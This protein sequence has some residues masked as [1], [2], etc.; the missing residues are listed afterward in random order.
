MRPLAR[1]NI[2]L[3]YFP[4]TDLTSTRRRPAMVLWAD[5]GQGDFIL[6]FIS[7]QNLFS[8]APDETVLLP[9]HPEFIL[10]G[11]SVLSKIR[12]LRA[13]EISE[14]PRVRQN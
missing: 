1:D 10:S 14:V 7:S 3:V 9:T 4:F 12:P 5:P 13:L 11:L 2:V 8:P 6:A